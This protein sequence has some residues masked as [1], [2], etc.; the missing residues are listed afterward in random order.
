MKSYL[1]CSDFLR[2][3]RW[4]FHSCLA[5]RSRFFSSS[6]SRLA[7]FCLKHHFHRKNQKK[8]YPQH[9]HDF[10]VHFS[11][12]LISK[13]SNCCMKISSNVLLKKSSFGGLSMLVKYWVANLSDYVLKLVIS[14]KFMKNS[15]VYSASQAVNQL[16]H[17]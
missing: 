10:F 4:Y 9:F 13:K 14:I 8:N 7:L 16:R 6:C 1:S 17:Y 15:F 3:F 12:T 2:L 11:S 5:P